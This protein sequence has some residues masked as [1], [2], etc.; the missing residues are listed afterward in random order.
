MLH[1]FKMKPEIAADDWGFSKGINE[2][3]LDLARVG[4]VQTVSLVANAPH[5]EHGLSELKNIKGVKFAWHMNFTA[6]RPLN[7]VADSSVLVQKQTKCFHTLKEFIWLWWSGKIK[8]L[9]LVAEAKAQIQFLKEM[10][11]EISEGDGHH[12]VHLVP[13][14]LELIQPLYTEFGIA[15]IRL[16]MEKSHLTSYLGSQCV[17]WKQ[18]KFSNLKLIIYGYPQK[19]HFKNPQEFLRTT[20]MGERP[21]LVHPAAY[22]DFKGNPYGDT[23]CEER[24]H[25]YHSLREWFL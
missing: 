17:W 13:G 7:Q 18:K 10:A 15:T 2:G 14:V 24:V 1:N 5:L 22:D 8:P 21:V 9:E 3:I 20:K 23:F 25:Q 6:G 12:H 11:G 19:K 16:P 4:I